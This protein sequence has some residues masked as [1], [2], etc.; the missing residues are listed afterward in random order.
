MPPQRQPLTLE[1]ATARVFIKIYFR[2][3]RQWLENLLEARKD[4]RSAYLLLRDTVLVECRQMP[5]Q[6]TT[7]G[8][9]ILELLAPRLTKEFGKIIHKYVKLALQVND[10]IWDAE[11]HTS[12]CSSMF[13]TVLTPGVQKFDMFFTSA[14][15]LRI[16]IFETLDSVPELLEFSI[17]HVIEN[18]SAI[19]ASKIH[20]LRNLQIFMYPFHCT[21]EIILQLRLNCPHL[22]V[23]EISDSKEVTNASAQHLM[24]LRELKFLD[25][26][27][28]Q[29]DD[30][31]YGLILAELPG[32]VNIKLHFTTDL[33]SRHITVVRL[34]TFTHINMYASH[35]NGLA[36]KCPNTS[37]ITLNSCAADLSGITAFRALRVLT[38]D[39]IHYGICNMNAVI[40]GIGHRLK[41][42]EVFRGM[43]VNLQEI[44]TL[45][46]FLVNLSLDI[47]TLSPLN[48]NLLNPNLPH[49]NN[50]INLKI[51]NGNFYQVDLSFIRYFVS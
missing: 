38:F 11:E 29:I 12:L 6:L 23:V 32:I 31:H 37:N 51:C 45:C 18:Q 46:P 15:F 50:L 2:K 1:E 13:R 35:I 25:L 9:A 28:T 27:G 36:Q 5:E 10:I 33:I 17:K 4:S 14:E 49:F 7:F 16:I 42:L 40:G 21:D 20:Y 34:H 3:C 47:L 24:E 22:N 43:G 44:I 30:E 19:L 41:D 8:P 48:G 39:V 26:C